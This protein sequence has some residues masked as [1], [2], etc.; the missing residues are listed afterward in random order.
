M[1]NTDNNSVK[2]VILQRIQDGEAA[3]RPRWHFVVKSL[4]VIAAVIILVFVLMII[5]SFIAFVMQQN[6]GWFAPGFGLR[7]LQPLLVSIPW[8][9]VGVSVVFVVL[10]EIMVRQYQFAYR[11]P[12]LLTLLG[13]LLVVF[14]GSAALAKG[15]VHYNVLERVE[16]GEFRAVK[17]LYKKKQQETS[18]P[19]VYMGNIQMVTRD[20]FVLLQRDDTEVYV[21]VG[22]HVRMKPGTDPSVGD[23]VTVLGRLVDDGLV[24]ARAIKPLDVRHKKRLFKQHGEQTKHERTRPAT[25]RVK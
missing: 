24:D 5:G 4:L 1:D 25:R 10:L 17:L 9:L 19:H 21:R 20:G 18:N 13:V 2:D 7:G 16:R 15:G 14:S 11:K 23:V 8:V 6:G 22:D 12:V 3:M